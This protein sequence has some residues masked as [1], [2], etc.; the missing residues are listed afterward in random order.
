[1]P[2][3]SSVPVPVSCRRGG[4]KHAPATLQL[5]RTTFGAAEK[6]TLLNAGVSRAGQQTRP[7]SESKSLANVVHS[8]DRVAFRTMQN[9]YMQVVLTSVAP[10]GGEQQVRQGRKECR[11]SWCHVSMLRVVYTPHCCAHVYTRARTHART[12]VRARVVCHLTLRRSAVTSR[13]TW[14]VFVHV[15]RLLAVVERSHAGGGERHGSGAGSQ[16]EW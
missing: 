14:C 2:A 16:R 3:R 13:T 12:H 7:A 5:N 4:G 9:N 15:V 1:M 11:N 6:W 8:C 10:Q